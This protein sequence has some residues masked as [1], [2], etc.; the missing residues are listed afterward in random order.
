[1]TRRSSRALPAFLISLAGCSDGPA[2]PD[3][4]VLVGQ[5]GHAEIP[6]E[7]LATHAGVTLD[8]GCGAFFVSEEAAILGDDQGFEVDGQYRP[9][10]FVVDGE[11]DATVSGTLERMNFVDFVTVTLILEGGGAGADPLEISLRRGQDF[12]GDPLPCPA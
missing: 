6:V 4:D 5:F 9:G 12:E 8:L 3:D 2:G 7:L 10:G 1:M 11:V